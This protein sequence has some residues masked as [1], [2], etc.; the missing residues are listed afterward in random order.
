MRALRTIV[1]ASAYLLSALASSNAQDVRPDDLSVCKSGAAAEARQACNRL[2]QRENLQSDR[3]R[4]ALL[5]MRGF[6]ALTSGD[7]NK[8]LLDFKEAIA[9]DPT[10]SYAHEGLAHVYLSKSLLAEARKS[11]DDAIKLTP[12]RTSLLVGRALSLFGLG[13]KVSARR[14]LERVLELDREKKSNYRSLALSLLART[15]RED[16]EQ[17]KAL[18]YLGQA[19]ENDASTGEWLLERALVYSKMGKLDL[20]LADLERARPK[21]SMEKEAAVNAAYLRG[22]LYA[23]KGERSKAIEGY[24][25]AI[26]L[27]PDQAIFYLER[28]AIYDELDRAKE[29][30]ADFDRAVILDKGG[31]VALSH[32]ADQY[33]KMQLP[34][35][36]IRDYTSIIARRPTATTALSARGVAYFAK[37]DLA[38]AREDFSRAASAKGNAYNALWLFTVSRRMG[39]EASPE[40]LGAFRS[41]EWPGPVVDLFLEVPGAEAAL[42]AL[43]DVG[44]RCEA[45]FFSGQKRLLKGDIPGARAEFQIARDRCPR[46]YLEYSGAVAELARAR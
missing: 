16:G 8:S 37:G 25:E 14:D 13:D 17:E 11:Y 40:T 12:N 4:G 45:A 23:Q 21:G 19:I 20:A 42:S 26:A 18:K 5:I 43:T 24:S 44:Q 38:R 28:G 15:L 36:A 9:S 10:N 2:L 1:A 6:G 7:E 34:D 46:S 31:T 33:R 39:A 27:D 30:I 35:E 41:K 29:A 22:K 32:R 3:R